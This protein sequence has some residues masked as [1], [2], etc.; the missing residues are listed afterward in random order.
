MYL[1]QLPDYKKLLKM[2]LSKDNFQTRNIKSHLLV[3]KGQG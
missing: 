1:I 2:C 3:L